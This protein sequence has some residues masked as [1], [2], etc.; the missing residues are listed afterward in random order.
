[1]V[2]SL[3]SHNVIQYLQEAGLCSSEDGASADSELPQSSKNRNFLVTLTGNRKL[4]VKQERCFGVDGIPHEFFNEWL[5]HQLVQQF[6]V[7]GNI[8]EIGTSVVHFDEVNS[9]LVRNYL[10]EYEELRSFY[11]D[12]SIFPE[13]IV[14]AIGNSLATLHRTTYSRREYRNFMATSPTGV[15]RYQFCNP[16]QGISAVSPEIFGN[17]P[18][19]ALQFYIFHQCYE[20]LE[21]AIADLAYEWNPCC[22]THNDLKLENILVH[23]RWQNLDNCLVRLIDWEAASWGEPAFDLG[24]LIADYLR[25]W[26]ESM[27]IDST[28]TWEESLQLAVIPVEILQ[29]TILALTRAYLQAFPMILQYRQDFI[30]RVVQFAGLALINQ[31]EQNL[32]YCQHFDNVG[33]NILQVAKTLLTMPQQSVETVFGVSESE[34]IEPLQKLQTVPKTAREQNLLRIYY[35]KPRLR[36]C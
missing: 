27:V 21:S 23:S 20:S 13:A 19:E 10:S 35:E 18:T 17:I 33:I 15:I 12:N 7:L 30:L 1:M 4:L 5:L 28:L 24:S 3:S 31:I 29:P 25:I 14:T 16:A 8:S 2:S 22:L 26:L 9:I 34:I 6:P 36:G 32:K 11:G